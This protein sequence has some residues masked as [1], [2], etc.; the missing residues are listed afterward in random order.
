VFDNAEDMFE[1]ESE[2]VNEEFVAR[3]DTYNLKVGGF[4]GFDYINSDWYSIHEES[5]DRMM[6]GALNASAALK[7][8][9]QN[10]EWK[11][12][13]N[14]SVSIGL[15]RYFSTVDLSGENAPFYG[16][17]H[18]DQT[19]ALLSEKAKLRVG[20]KNSSFGTMWITNLETHESKKIKKDDQIPSGWRKG[21]KIIKRT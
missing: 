9:H 1:M 7:E 13:F 6:K 19:K 2:L 12:S 10:E 3:D 17:T 8:L 20:E 14:K 4:G 21:R 18:S 5:R 15:Q 11:Q 16:K